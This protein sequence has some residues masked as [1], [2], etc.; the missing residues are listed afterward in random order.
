M[1]GD[2]GQKNTV[3]LYDISKLPIRYAA[4][5]SSNSSSRQFFVVAVTFPAMPTFSEYASYSSSTSR[6]FRYLVPE[7]SLIN[8]C[9][10]GGPCSAS[11]NFGVG[12]NC[13]FPHSS[14]RRRVWLCRNSGFF[15][16]SQRFSPQASD[17]QDVFFRPR[18][19]L[20]RAAWP[21]ACFSFWA[22]LFCPFFEVRNA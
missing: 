12:I 7:H 22:R 13:G 1:P 2:S 16:S 20:T 18:V 4:L 21:E 9:P 15:Y 11:P 17:C 5:V 10:G 3:D 14:R 19:F 6:T 8:C